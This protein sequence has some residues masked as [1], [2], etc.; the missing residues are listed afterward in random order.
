MQRMLVGSLLVVL[1]LG[2]AACASVKTASEAA[3][4]GFDLVMTAIKVV[5]EGKVVADSKFT[6][7]I[8]IKNIGNADMPADIK[9]ARVQIYEGKPVAAYSEKIPSLKAG[10]EYVVKLDNF[11]GGVMQLA[12]KAPGDHAYVVKLDPKNYLPETN[13]QN[14]QMDIT[15]KVE[16]KE[17]PKK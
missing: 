9:D 8:T 10:A 12:Y 5:P 14:N 13:E 15:V 1:V 2:L 16:P 17:E 3:P 11:Q 4:K 6:F 7:E